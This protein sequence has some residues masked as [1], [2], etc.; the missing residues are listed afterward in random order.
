MVPTHCQ[1][2]YNKAPLFTDAVFEFSTDSVTG[3][4]NGTVDVTV[5]TSSTL[6]ASVTVSLEFV[7]G[8]VSE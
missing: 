2:R 1:C 5:M 8:D 3:T 6:N 4:E 7:A